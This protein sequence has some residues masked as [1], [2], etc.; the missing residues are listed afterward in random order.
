MSYPRLGVIEF[1]KA[2]LDTEDLDPVYVMLWK[3]EIEPN[4]LRRWL[5]A[6][7]MFYHSGVASKLSYY[8]KQD[9]FLRASLYAKSSSHTPRGTERRHFRGKACLNCIDWFSE[10]YKSPEQAIDHLLS[11]AHGNV[12]GVLDFVKRKWPLFGPWIGFKIA[13]MLERLA[14][15]Q[16]SF[17]IKTL[18]M[19]SEPT[20]GAELV[21]ERKGWNWDQLRVSGT[22]SKLLKTFSK[23]KAPPRY[24]R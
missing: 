1:G 19:Y 18:E 4:R 2:L 9:F 13:D 8:E 17:P 23:Y 16:I 5:L 11:K 15:A 3:A 6:Y 12:F 7:W 10:K 22:V 24:E 21:C 20:K 14:I